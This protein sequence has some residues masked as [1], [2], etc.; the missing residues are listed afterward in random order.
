MTVRYGHIWR[1]NANRKYGILITSADEQAPPTTAKDE[2]D[3]V[4]ADDEEDEVGGMVARPA[5]RSMGG[6]Q[7]SRQATRG[8]MPPV[9]EMLRRTASLTQP[10]A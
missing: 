7:L 6:S 8:E 4:K 1:E 5:L 9:G 3:A 2:E 10:S